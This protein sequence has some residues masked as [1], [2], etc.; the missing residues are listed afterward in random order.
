MALGTN[1]AIGGT[2]KDFAA[3]GVF[4]SVPVV[5]GVPVE[6]TQG[7]KKRGKIRGAQE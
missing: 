4:F 1:G 2:I 7:G 6:M 3:A 5:R